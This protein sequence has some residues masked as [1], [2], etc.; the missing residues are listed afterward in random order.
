MDD[1]LFELPRIRAEGRPFVLC[2]VTET[3]GS[4]PRK[5]GAKMI[6]F[7]DGR[8][9]GTVG[10]GSVEQQAIAD[11]LQSL[12]SGKPFQ[13][14]YELEEDLNMQCGGRVS[15]YFE[16]LKK[17]LN[18]FIFGAGHVGREVGVYASGLGFKIHFV[19][20]RPA[21][22]D[23]FDAA[24][25]ETIAGDYL[26]TARKLELTPRDFVVITT[27]G[28]A[29]DEALL[30]I[31]APR[32]LMYL[33]MIGSKRKVNEARKRFLEQGTLN[34]EQLDHVDMPIGVPFR[35]ETPRE[36]AISIVARLI[37]VKNTNNL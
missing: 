12:R 24:Y 36:I 37:D 20:N 30:E 29:F 35:A 3:E 14:Y 11:A 25:A 23:E 21:I 17:D 6:V 10:G 22:F 28:H 8:I 7:D 31:L 26:E 34:S 2:I 1:I 27:Q 18:L 16:P 32:S 19:D 9:L 33:G 15:I 4:T 13:K 5:E